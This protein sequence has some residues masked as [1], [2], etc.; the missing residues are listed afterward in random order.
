M[1][2]AIL[3]FTIAAVSLGAVSPAYAASH[4]RSCHKV[5]VHHHWQNR[6]R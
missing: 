2:K 5:M 4:H 3:A 6:C 1:K